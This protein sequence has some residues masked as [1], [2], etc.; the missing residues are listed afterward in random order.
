M[1]KRRDHG[2]RSDAA[3]GEAAISTTRMVYPLSGRRI[4]SLRNMMFFTIQVLSD[5]LAAIE[6]W[7]NNSVLS[8]HT[9][10]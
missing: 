10:V 9:V 7:Y 5:S 2:D 3:V 4:L 6:T 1:V 8:I